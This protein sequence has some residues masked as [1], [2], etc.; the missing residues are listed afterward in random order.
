MNLHALHVATNVCYVTNGMMMAPTLTTLL[1]WIVARE[2]WFSGVKRQRMILQLVVF[3]PTQGH[4]SHSTQCMCLQ[5]ILFVQLSSSAKHHT[6][7]HLQ[8]IQDNVLPLSSGLN[9]QL[10]DSLN[11][12]NMPLSQLSKRFGLV[13]KDISLTCTTQKTIIC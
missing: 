1:A 3:T 9:I 2:K 13:E 8:R 12:L 7:H 4:H 6:Q 11:F 5:H 10:L